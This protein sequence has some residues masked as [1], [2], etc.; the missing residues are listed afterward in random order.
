M[1]YI[2]KKVFSFLSSGFV[3][4]SFCGCSN[5]SDVLDDVSSNVIVTSTLSSSS[6]SN[7]T[8]STTEKILTSTSAST[9]SITS[10]TT[11]LLT[12][13]TAS[14]VVTDAFV[15]SDVDSS[16]SVVLDYFFELGNSIRSN[17]NSDE[18]LDKGKSYFVY[19]VD[20]LFY[21]GEIKGIKFSDLTDSV[22]QQLLNDISTIDSLICSK[23]P[24]YKENIKEGYGSA[25]NKAAEII[26]QGSQNIKEFS[27]EKLGEENYNKIKEYKDLFIETAFGDFD[28]FLEIVGNGKQKIKDWYEGL[29]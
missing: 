22:K 5:N 26:R 18:L 2:N 17:F 21:D 7:T 20:F 19:C 29:R 1:K 11:S 15:T 6:I 4:L 10:S 3:L 24:N 14:T 25:Y 9:G 27:K 16:D 28:D 13:T 8:S 12:S 23:F